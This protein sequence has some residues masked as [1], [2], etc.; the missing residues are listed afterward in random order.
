MRCR[1]GG[2]NHGNVLFG[3]HPDP[4]V[5]TLGFGVSNRVGPCDSNSEIPLL[6]MLLHSR[7]NGAT[8]SDVSTGPRLYSVSL[9]SSG[10]GE[11]AQTPVDPRHW[12]VVYGAK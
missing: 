5:H 9:P 6:V 8:H 2:R 4:G 7:D 12:G 1:I 10:G 3:L 11:R